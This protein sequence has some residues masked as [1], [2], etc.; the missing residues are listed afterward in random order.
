[1]GCDMKRGW[2]LTFLVGLLIG[3]S[4]T[5]IYWYWQ[6]S[7]SAEDGALELLDKLAAV[8]RRI[9]T[10][11]GV[12][13]AQTAVPPATVSQTTTVTDEVPS[14]LLRPSI[15]ESEELTQVK[16]I[17]PVFAGRL[18]TAGIDTLTKLTAVSAADL[19]GALQ[20]S[21]NRA[22]TILKAASDLV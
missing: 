5:L 18:Q 6:K 2:S 7:T 8:D 10:F 9:R 22:E 3:G 11:A 4:A 1:M 19:A 13:S 15:T 17:G 16:G 12:P 21:E 14:F 20:I